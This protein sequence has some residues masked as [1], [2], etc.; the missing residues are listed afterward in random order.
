MAGI[1]FTP[2]GGTHGAKGA[3]S[4]SNVFSGTFDG[5]GHLIS[6]LT[7][8]V[9]EEVSDYAQVGLFSIVASADAADYAEVRNL[10]FANVSVTVDISGGF[11]AAG[12]LAGEVNGYAT[13]ENIGILD[14]VVTVNGANQSDTVG[15]AGVI[16][17]CRTSASMGNQHRGDTRI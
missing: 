17:E 12:T 16:G 7:I 1:D 11:T 13:V 2:I 14:G 4:G 6:N 15:A 8:Q 5:Q 9:S 10:L 3:V